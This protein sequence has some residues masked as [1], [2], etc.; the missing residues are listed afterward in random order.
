MFL[1]VLLNIAISPLSTP[2]DSSARKVVMGQNEVFQVTLHQMKDSVELR[3]TNLSSDT[4]RY[5]MGFYAYDSLGY[6]NRFDYNVLIHTRPLG[7][8]FATPTIG[9]LPGETQLKR[10]KI[11]PKLYE[12][13]SSYR[14]YDWFI[15]YF[16]RA[17]KHY[18]FIILS[19]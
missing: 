8:K 9:I 14:R 13:I 1:L 17:E 15:G 4:I 19:N 18:E 11:G 12:F 3:I 7:G 5:Y 6:D 16:S 2:A 10:H